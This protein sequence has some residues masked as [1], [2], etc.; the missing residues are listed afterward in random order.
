MFYER[1][2]KKQD[3]RMI[4]TEEFNKMNFAEN[5][6]VHWLPKSKSAGD[7]AKQGVGIL[8]FILA[9]ILIFLAAYLPLTYKWSQ[10]TWSDLSINEI[11]YHLF[12][13]MEGTGTGMVTQHIV[14]CVVPSVIIAAIFVAVMIIIK[15]KV[16]YTSFI[17]GLVA[18]I[19]IVI[20]ANTIASF[21]KKMDVSEYVANQSQYSSF[22]D[23][24]Y[25]DPASVD[26][27]F[28][29]QKR[30][31]IYIFLESTETTFS[32]KESG[33]AFDVDVMP[34]LTQIAIENESF[35]GGDIVNGG[36]AMTGATWTIGAMFA[37][38][39]GLPLNISIDKNSMSSQSEFFPGATVLGD[40]LEE[41]GY[42][43]TLLLGSDAAFGGRK[44]YF[45]T[46]GNYA[47]KDYNYYTSNGT[48][49]SDYYVWWGYEDKYLFEN[50]KTELAEL[51]STGEPFNLTMLTVDTHFEDGYVCSECRDEF[52][53]Q[54]SNVYACISRQLSEFLDWL[55]EQP[56]Y[57]NTTIVISGDHLTMDS[58]FCN[59][60]DDNYDRR[61]LTTIINSAVQPETDEFREYTTFDNFPT[62]LAAMG[63]EI[64]G[65]KLAL[66]TNLFSSEKTLYEIYG[67]EVL[68]D[69]LSSKSELMDNLT[70]GIAT[71]M[72]TLTPLEYNSET[73]MI[74]VLVS[75]L[76]ASEE[77]V[78][79]SGE[80]WKESDK[81]DALTYQAED[82]G[83]GTWIFN[84]P[85]SDFAYRGGTYNFSATAVN[86]KIAN[87]QLAATSFE[88]HDY[89]MESSGN[90]Q[91][92]FT[93]IQV[94]E[95]DY[96]KGTVYASYSEH[97]V[98]NIVSVMFAVWKEE[99]RSDMRMYEAASTSNG[100]FDVEINVMDYPFD[101]RN[102]SI[103]AFVITTDGNGTWKTY[104]N[105]TT[106]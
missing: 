50:A 4:K 51:S 75:N 10:D 52:G 101:N 6:G 90:V 84:I 83:D 80:M 70:A 13:P 12:M 76:N 14:K 58:D 40:I 55:K 25:V 26:L 36:H 31:L 34:E 67:E 99:D 9:T 38:T 79:I 69:G 42:N 62:T 74:Q 3:Y 2:E 98:S 11:V 100:T 103:Q 17:K 81:S 5:K 54:Y 104:S 92:T 43:Q 68:N 94:S 59:G 66:G 93:G 106:Q 71:K 96:S 41:Q 95:F 1:S 56:Y 22:I 91:Q 39:S 16:T 86:G 61:V 15:R 102:F 29:E 105:F 48:L 77:L 82:R 32:D 23:E 87:Y 89:Q 57:D 85:F 47:M 44:L 21:W 8:G 63:V 73:K 7:R 72:A 97:D 27:K 33:G 37:Q 24:N 45:E 28:P 88:V 46:H 19:S 18:A 53:D 30:N 20:I 35:S 78:G 64:P 65:N 60:I 49:P